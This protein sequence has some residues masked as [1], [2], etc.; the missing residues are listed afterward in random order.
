MWE[1]AKQRELSCIP[2]VVERNDPDN[3]ST[4]TAHEKAI[5][6]YEWALQLE[7]HLFP[8]AVSQLS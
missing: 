7:I 3:D 6:S 5:V 8:G 2:L 4:E 1:C